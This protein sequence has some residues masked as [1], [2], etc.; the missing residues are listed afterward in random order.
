MFLVKNRSAKGA[1]LLNKCC[2]RDLWF[3]RG[4]KILA[5]KALLRG[6]IPFIIMSGIASLLYFQGKHLDAKEAS[7]AQHLPN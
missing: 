5:M 7:E 6:G 3:E 1:Q 4:L 2:A